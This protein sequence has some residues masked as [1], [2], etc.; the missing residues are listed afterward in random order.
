[1][2]D[3]NNKYTTNRDNKPN[4]KKCEGCGAY[5]QPNRTCKY[6][7]YDVLTEWA[8]CHPKAKKED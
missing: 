6:W 8:C 5:G 4:L 3:A 1:M 2:K 7:S